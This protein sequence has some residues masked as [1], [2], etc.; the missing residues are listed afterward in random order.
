MLQ[1]ESSIRNVSDTALWMAVYRARESERTDAL[2]HDPFANRLAGARGEG[3]AASMPFKGRDSWPFVMR[4]LLFDQFIAEEVER[5]TDTVINLGTGLDTRPYRMAL[6]ATL[7]W[8]EADLPQIID[9]KEEILAGEKPVCALERVRL[10]LAG[11][12][13]R[14]Q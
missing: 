12:D 9:Y 7:R 5:G 6:P 1:T 3:I 13:G 4:T 14:R 8:V 10:D 2:F 11:V